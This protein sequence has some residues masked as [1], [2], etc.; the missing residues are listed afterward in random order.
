MAPWCSEDKDLSLTLSVADDYVLDPKNPRKTG[1]KFSLAVY[2]R[3]GGEGVS[4]SITFE[5]AV[6]NLESK[7]IS[8]FLLYPRYT[9]YIGGI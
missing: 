6:H 3:C 8:Y 1:Y 4:N 2:N 9:K 7:N 5:E